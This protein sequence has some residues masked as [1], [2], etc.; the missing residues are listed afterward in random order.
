MSEPAATVLTMPA[1]AKPARLA[2][3]DSVRQVFHYTVE[4]GK[5]RDEQMEEL[6][7]PMY[8]IHVARQLRPLDHVLVVPDDQSYFAEFIVLQSDTTT[9]V[10]LR[11]L[12]GVTLE[13]TGP[14]DAALRDKTGL[15]AKYSGPHVKWTVRRGDKVLAEQLQSEQAAYQWI[16]AHTQGHTRDAK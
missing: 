3:A 10:V 13:G 2:Q 11:P 14:R 12:M 5:S 1:R 7:D 15:Y 6:G 16:H 4:G 8:W 9:G